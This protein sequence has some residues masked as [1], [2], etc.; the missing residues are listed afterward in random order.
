MDEKGAMMGVIGQQR[1]IVSKST[2]RPKYAQDGNWEWGTL[3][4]YVSLIGT[5]LSPWI[6]F[7][8]KTQQKKWHTKI[9]ELRGDK[10][11]HICV[12]ENG[13]TGWFG[14]CFV[15]ETAKTQNGEYRLLL[16][17]GHSSHISI[18]TIKFCLE[19]KIISLFLSPHTTHLL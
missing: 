4:E 13:W 7:K 6:I 14:E 1:Y 5:V 12:S 16:W 15:P 17:D 2:K 9:K 11:Y 8:G 3:V 19:K 10:P 18:E